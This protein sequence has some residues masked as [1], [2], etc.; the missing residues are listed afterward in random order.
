MSSPQSSPHEP[1]PNL[2]KK[3]G[4]VRQGKEAHKEGS[5]TGENGELSQW[6]TQHPACETRG[7]EKAA[8][9][10]QKAKSTEEMEKQSGN[11][12]ALSA[13]R[14]SLVITRSHNC[15]PS[16]NRTQQTPEALT[17]KWHGRGVE[18]TPVLS[19]FPNVNFMIQ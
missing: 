9:E 18:G 8:V 11:G 6:E 1:D 19:A 14:S 15:D 12:R 16:P 4:N 13:D 2:L 10:A 7:V 5:P 3:E 17:N